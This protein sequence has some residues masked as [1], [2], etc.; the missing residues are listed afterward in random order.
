[1]SVADIPR[2]PVLAER[3]TFDAGQTDGLS[4]PEIVE[5]AEKE[6]IV[7]ASKHAGGSMTK[8]AEQLKIPRTSLYYKFKKFGIH[9]IKE[10]GV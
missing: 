8:A 4:L 7:S 1:M 9:I 5:N 2:Q 10:V 3:Q 6:A